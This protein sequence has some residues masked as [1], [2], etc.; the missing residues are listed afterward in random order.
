MTQETFDYCCAWAMRVFGYENCS[1][2]ITHVALAW[3]VV[4]AGVMIYDL[5]GGF[6]DDREIERRR[7]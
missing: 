1:D 6:D 2:P 7:W 4:V 3:A 5:L